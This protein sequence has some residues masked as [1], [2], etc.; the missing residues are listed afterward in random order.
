MLLDGFVM[1]SSSP[2]LGSRCVYQAAYLVGRHVSANKFIA[3]NPTPNSCI[4]P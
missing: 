3:E 1:A 4:V 2:I